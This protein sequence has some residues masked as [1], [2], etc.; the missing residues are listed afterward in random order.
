MK[1]TCTNESGEKLQSSG[2]VNRQ[3]TTTPSENENDQLPKHEKS[4]TSY[5]P[6]FDYGGQFKDVGGSSG[7][8]GLH[9]SCRQHQRPRIL[10]R[11]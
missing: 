8:Q 7:K 4:S 6:K 5:K 2:W 11:V 1:N 10:L 3:G 9:V